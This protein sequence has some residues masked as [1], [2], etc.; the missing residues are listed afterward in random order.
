MNLKLT[1]SV[2]M[3]LLGIWLILTGLQQILSV[4]NPTVNAL[5]PLLAIAAGLLIALNR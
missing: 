4:G 2:G 3:L 5:L 1:K